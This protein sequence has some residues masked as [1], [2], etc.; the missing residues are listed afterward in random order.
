[1]PEPRALVP[2]DGEF[3]SRGTTVAKWYE[4]FAAENPSSPSQ[5][6]SLRRVIAC[7]IQID[8]PSRGLGAGERNGFRG[9]RWC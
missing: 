8:Q 3:K 6:A 7:R 5:F 4:N 9:T 1:M 2:P